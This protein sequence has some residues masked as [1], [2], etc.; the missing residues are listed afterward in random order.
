MVSLKKKPSSD[1]LLRETAAIPGSVLA[2]EH[3][4]QISRIRTNEVYRRGLL[5]S[6]YTVIAQA[7]MR[8]LIT[9]CPSDE[10]IP[11]YLMVLKKHHV[12]HVVRV[13][14]PLYDYGTLVDAG[15]EFH[16]WPSPDGVAPPPHILSAWVKLVSS[17]FHEHKVA[18]ESSNDATFDPP[19]TIA[20]HCRH[21]LGRA[22]VLVAV[23]MIE[24]GMEPE[25]A[26]GLIRA[27]R[28]G[29]INTNQLQFLNSYVRTP[30][31]VPSAGPKSGILSI[32]RNALT[33]RGSMKSMRSRPASPVSTTLTS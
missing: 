5:P 22:P 8:F 10:E 12:K 29:A 23:A 27:N 15:L 4:Y 26:V 18:D 16:D 19:E 24:A 2:L 7:G 21:G 1:A 33:R 9:D 3:V 13:C 32:A 31:D 6:R 28:R 25:E 30:K 17:T 14:E 11:A 20:I